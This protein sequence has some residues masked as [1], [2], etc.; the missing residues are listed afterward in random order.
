MLGP[1]SLA[2]YFAGCVDDVVLDA[3]AEATLDEKRVTV[4]AVCSALEHCTFHGLAAA[5]A[6]GGFWSLL[7]QLAARE[8]AMFEP[9]VLLTEM[10]SLRTGRGFCRAWLRQSL[11]RSNLAYM[12]RQ[13]TQAKHAD[14]LECVYTPAALVRDA[15]ALA[16]VLGALERLDPLPL[17]LKIDFRQLD[18]ALEPVGSP[19]L[20]PVRAP[21][22]ADAQLLEFDLEIDRSGSRQ[23]RRSKK[24]GKTRGGRR[25]SSASGAPA[26]EPLA[27]IV[28]AVPAQVAAAP[29]ERPAAVA[30][31]EEAPA[32]PPAV[33]LPAVAPPPAAASAAAAPSATPSAATL[34][35]SPEYGIARTLAAQIAAHQPAR[36]ALVRPSKP[37]AAPFTRIVDAAL[38]PPF[39]VQRQ[40]ARAL[41]RSHCA[42]TPRPRQR[43]LSATPTPPPADAIDMRRTAAVVVSAEVTFCRFFYVPLH[44]TRILLTI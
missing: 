30:L 8:R 36:G 4:R 44:F 1:R 40:R 25:R 41:I 19:R 16:T 13:A 29:V 26:D 23:R 32:D 5:S 43:L 34:E 21:H 18:D 7:E 14:I 9:C 10:L 24:A 22:R 6:G 38:A 27:G 20:R 17:Q 12:L 35:R 39:A 11:L 2:A 3:A 33:A 28:E 15:E 31:V 42:A 37:T